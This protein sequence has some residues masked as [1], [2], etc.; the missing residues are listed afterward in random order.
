MSGV[1]LVTADDDV[2]ALAKREKLHIWNPMKM[3][4]IPRIV[5]G[6]RKLRPQLV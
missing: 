2:E 3:R 1:V 6:R 4:T 5:P